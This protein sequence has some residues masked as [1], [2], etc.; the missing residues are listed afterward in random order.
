MQWRQL[1]A[2]LLI[3][4]G[5]A[6]CQARP[7]EP[8]RQATP[9]PPA[10]VLVRPAS[11][12][13]VQPA[14]PDERAQVDKVI[15]KA[16]NS[17]FALPQVR[18][19]NATVARRINETLLAYFNQFN[20]DTLA[21]TARQAV[22]KAE[23]TFHRDNE[24]GFRGYEFEVLY[25]AYY[26][27]SLS[28]TA[29]ELGAHEVATNT[30]AVFNLR[31]GQELALPDLVADTLALKRSWQRQMNENT[32]ASLAEFIKNN[33]PDSA[34]LAY[35]KERV[36]WNDRRRAVDLDSP[37]DFA[38]TSAG[39]RLFCYYD[40]PLPWTDM[41]PPSEYLFTWAE[42]RP[43]WRKTGPWRNLLAQ[44]ARERPQ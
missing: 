6:Y 36:S 40:L 34:D 7:D 30:H 37:P 25:N 33:R 22:R 18:L 19:T 21:R 14:P 15:G 29:Y 8:T 26:V 24:Q 5:L 9:W 38:L 13:E 28:L 10:K 11:V 20:E 23:K 35:Y 41:Q 39:L 2:W 43:W 12:A 32:A 27:L 31:T 4:G 3:S 1:P 16:K 17:D 42:L 44:A